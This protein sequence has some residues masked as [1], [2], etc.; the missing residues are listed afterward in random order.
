MGCGP[1]K[2]TKS[3]ASPVANGSVET[4]YAFKGGADSHHSAN[5]AAS[6]SHPAPSLHGQSL[7]SPPQQQPT[8][9]AI[10]SQQL[11]QFSGIPPLAALST[12]NGQTSTS[13]TATTSL[14]NGSSNNNNMTN[15][16]HLN[17]A[18]SSLG[19]DGDASAQWNDL[20][21]PLRDNLLDPA[22]VTAVV[23]EVMNQLT[24]SRLM[25]TE[26]TF[27]VRRVRHVVSSLPP[28]T[29][30]PA[31][32]M[33]VKSLSRNAANSLV[34]L[35]LDGR[36]TAEKHHLLSSHVFRRMLGGQS[37]ILESIPKPDTKEEA[38]IFPDP[39]EAA[40]T[41]LLHLSSSSIIQRSANIAEQ[42]AQA[43]GLNLDVNE[44]VKKT[45]DGSS[46]ST[47]KQQQQAPAPPP[48]PPP[49]PPGVSKEDFPELPQGITLQSFAFLMA[50]ALRT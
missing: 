18:N 20:W 23:E 48:P 21:E 30:A 44:S 35:E 47:A 2:S 24:D 38:L 16:L 3:P 43:A 36:V 40:Y 7:L 42:S 4:P 22:D 37:H 6:G 13:A 46:P 32:K 27:L 17:N 5:S 39:I 14:A 9:N 49:A 31:T 12:G 8:T 10:Q 11:P 45:D 34:Q 1:S 29:S 25:P 19:N 15:A 41:L 26:V 50:L 28:R 33:R